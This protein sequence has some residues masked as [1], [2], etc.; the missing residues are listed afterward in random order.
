MMDEGTPRTKGRQLSADGRANKKKE[1]SKPPKNPK[2]G[3]EEKM[4]QSCVMAAK[5][6]GGHLTRQRS[7]PL[8]TAADGLRQC[9]LRGDADPSDPHD[10]EKRFVSNQLLVFDDALEEIKAGAKRSCW[11]WFVL[12][13]APF[14]VNGKEVGSSMN[15]HFALRGDEAVK[16]FLKFERKGVNLRQNYFTILHAVKGQLEQGNT[17]LRLFGPLDVNKATNSFQLFHRIAQ[18]MEDEKLTMLSQNVLNLVAL[19]KQKREART[20]TNKDDFSRSN[21]MTV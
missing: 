7:A 20:P 4:V 1:K 16:A 3:K 5:S 8:S 13:T 11:L 18:E 6:H 19:D 21:I 14:I 10:L 15:R 12:P 17:M 2:P 9:A